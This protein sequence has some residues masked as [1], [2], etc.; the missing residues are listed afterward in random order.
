[1]RFDL[2]PHQNNKLD[3]TTIEAP[4]LEMRSIRSSIGTETKR[5]V[6][7]S[8]IEIG[9]TSFEIELTLIDR[10]MMG[11]R[12]LLGRDAIKSRYLV[13][14]EKSFVQSHELNRRIH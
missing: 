11:F 4:L 8:T 12:M 1:M 2:Y 9:E 3:G 13:N 6:I 7:I 14:C 5:P 10:N